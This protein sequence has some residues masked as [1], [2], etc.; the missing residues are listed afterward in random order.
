MNP[1]NTDESVDAVSVDYGHVPPQPRKSLSFEASLARKLKNRSENLMDTFLK[2]DMDSDGF[3][4]R[5]DLRSSLHNMYGINL[6][7]SQL[8]AIFTRFAFFD[9]SCAAEGEFSYSRGM[10]YADF[11]NYIHDT[12]LDLEISSDEYGSTLDLILADPTDDPSIS[13]ATDDKLTAR[14]ATTTTH[15]IILMTSTTTTTPLDS[16][17]VSNESSCYSSTDQE[18]C[19]HKSDEELILAL[20]RKCSTTTTE[21][22]LA[23]AFERFDVF[24]TGKIGPS[25]ICAALSEMGVGIS[26]Q[27]AASLISNFHTDDDGIFLNKA[28]FVSMISTTVTRH[29]QALANVLNSTA[30]GCVRQLSFPTDQLFGSSCNIVNNKGS[31]GVDPSCT[32]SDTDINRIILEFRTAAKDHFKNATQMFHKL[33]KENKRLIAHDELIKAFEELRVHITQA[34]AKQIVSKFDTEGSGGLKF[35]QFLNLI[36]GGGEF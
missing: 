36:S 35:Y 24:N 7:E 17:Q 20:S 23:K 10:R 33:D 30:S 26:E 18:D 25:D 28:E 6:T 3:I 22:R 19:S 29:N 31:V 5:F 11:V 4:S 13:N 34:Q 14:K 9:H 27:R 8:D 12:A 2:L 32:D 16:G 21:G 1:R 15:K